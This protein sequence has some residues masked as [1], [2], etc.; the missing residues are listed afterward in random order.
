MKSITYSLKK[1][2]NALT[3]KTLYRA[4]VQANGMVGHE[5]LANLMAKR[6]RQDAATWR[7]FLDVLADEIDR[8]LLDGTRIKLGRLLTGFAIRGTFKSENERFDPEKHQ[9]VVMVR[10]LDP[11]RE[12]MAAVVPQ[13]DL[14]SQ[15]TCIF[16]SAMDEVTKRPSEVTGTNRLLIQ[17]L[18]LGI[19]PD[20][21]D[22]G[23]WLANPKTGEI[24]A[25]ATV[26]CSD[27]QTV[28]CVFTEPP[29][30]G[31][32]TLVIACR[33]GERETLAPAVARVKNFTVK[34]AEGA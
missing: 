14:S 27:S 11:L 1:V 34:S 2:P 20:N 25:T 8:Q 16:G 30:P 21:P 32:Y 19:S 26:E 22:E 29:E 15:L 24:V 5:E 17:G 10:M 12:Y 4:S 9:L 6:T 28:D 18:R 31:T 3:D 7:Y 13:N 33:N 23:V